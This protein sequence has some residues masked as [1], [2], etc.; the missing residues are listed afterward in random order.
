M[1]TNPHIL[2][3]IYFKCS[4]ISNLVLIFHFSSCYSRQHSYTLKIFRSIILGFYKSCYSCT[5][6]NFTRH[7]HSHIF[8]FIV[9]HLLFFPFKFPLHNNP[10]LLHHICFNCTR[11]SNLVI[12]FQF[13]SYYCS[14][15][16][17]TLKIFRATVVAFTKS[18]HSTTNRRFIR[19]T[20]SH[21]FFV[22]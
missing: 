12:I 7:I 22:L 2:H 3:H 6:R 13:F 21:I 16:S 19:P 15:H 5:N 4:R 11:I 17:Y 1:P 10:H 18:C 9:V 20:H 14:Q 8:R